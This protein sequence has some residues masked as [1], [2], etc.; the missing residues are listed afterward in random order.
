MLKRLWQRFEKR[1]GQSLLVQVTRRREF[2]LREK[3]LA[4]RKRG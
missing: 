1:L 3:T 2:F 4:I